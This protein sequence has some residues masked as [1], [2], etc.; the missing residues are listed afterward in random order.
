MRGGCTGVP[1]PPRVGSQAILAPPVVACPPPPPVGLW[2]VVFIAAAV[3]AVAPAVV[4][5]PPP[6][7]M[8][9]VV[10]VAFVAAVCFLVL[11]LDTQ[12]FGGISYVIVSFGVYHGCYF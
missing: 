10:A 6:V 9:S 4:P 1:H 12:R 2:F 11:A 3:S 8:W 5:P 7:V